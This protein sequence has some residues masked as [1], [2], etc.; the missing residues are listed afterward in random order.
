MLPQIHDTQRPL[1]KLAF[2]P[3]CS[4]STAS[5]ASSSR[6][7]R[8]PYPPK[9]LLTPQSR[10]RTKSWT[11]VDHST[12]FGLRLVTAVV[13]QMELRHWPTSVSIF[14]SRAAFSFPASVLGERFLCF[15]SLWT[16]AFCCVG[17][18]VLGGKALMVVHWGSK[19]QLGRMDGRVNALEASDGLH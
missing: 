18:G 16:N 2:Q 14:H 1:G 10:E 17:S 4:V 7:P 9:A 11:I 6:M 5:S 12:R 19:L 13:S 3:P 8:P 15:C